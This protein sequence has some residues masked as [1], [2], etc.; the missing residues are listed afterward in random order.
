MGSM[1]SKDVVLCGH[2]TVLATSLTGMKMSAQ[3]KPRR[4]GVPIGTILGIY[5]YP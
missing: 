3:K 1:L 4:Y 5:G 2:L